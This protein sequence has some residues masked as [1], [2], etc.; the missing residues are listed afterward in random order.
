MQSHTHTLMKIALNSI[1]PP[2]PNKKTVFFFYIKQ[3]TRLEQAMQTLTLS[4]FAQ[5]DSQS[6]I[7]FFPKKIIVFMSELTAQVS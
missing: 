6:K 7:L 2:P 1:T 5:K 4:S 3:N